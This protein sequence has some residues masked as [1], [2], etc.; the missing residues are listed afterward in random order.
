MTSKFELDLASEESW[1]IEFNKWMKEH[2]R[3]VWGLLEEFSEEMAVGLNTGL[4]GIYNRVFENPV[5]LGL[6]EDRQA[7]EVVRREGLYRIFYKCIEISPNRIGWEDVRTWTS[8]EKPTLS[9]REFDVMNLRFGLTDGV[10]LTHQECADI[11]G[12]VEY[13]V[14]QRIRSAM[15]KLKN[16]ENREIL[17][18]CI[19][20]EKRLRYE[21]GW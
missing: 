19:P 8:W 20:E 12:I 21:G 7:L 18:D 10:I 4:S 3:K 6:Y 14:S 1:N 15:S 16:P 11:L 17:L 13:T 5:G 2:E 9:P